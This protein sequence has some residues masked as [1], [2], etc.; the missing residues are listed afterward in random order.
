MLF[1][2]IDLSDVVP[3]DVLALRRGQRSSVLPQ[4]SVPPST[5][6]SMESML[7]DPT[8]AD[9]IFVF[10][11]ARISAHRNVLCARSEYFKAMLL[12]SFQ[13]GL[14]PAAKRQKASTASSSDVLE[15][16]IGDTTPSAFKAILRY[17]YTDELAFN[18]DDIVQVM[19]K[20]REIQLNRVFDFCLKHCVQSLSPGNAAKWLM[21]ADEHAIDM[22]RAQALSYITRNIKHVRKEA[23]ATLQR[24]SQRKSSLTF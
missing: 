17:I 7:D 8:F 2:D 20:A 15:V 3:R 16:T 19:S 11:G 4:L 21:Q 13:E 24:R 22:L 18:D 6:S 23:P 14:A 5:L 10:P 9:V 1:C 12:G